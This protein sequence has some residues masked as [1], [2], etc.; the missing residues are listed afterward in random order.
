MYSAKATLLNCLFPVVPKE[1]EKNIKWY[2][3][4]CHILILLMKYTKILWKYLKI[5]NTQ[6][7]STQYTL[8]YHAF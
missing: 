2:T 4:H 6:K 1:K 8:Q 7:F 5:I 3:K